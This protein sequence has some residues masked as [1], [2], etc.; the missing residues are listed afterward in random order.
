MRNQFKGFYTPK[1]NELANL[2]EN[3]NTIFVFDTNVL[4]NFYS[5]EENTRKDFFGVLDRICSRVWLPHQVVLEYQMRRLEIIDQERATFDRIL[6]CFSDI[7]NKI[8]SK[9]IAELKI[10]KRLPILAEALEGLLEEIT[11]LT[12]KF[13]EDIFKKQ[14]NL[15]PDVRS[16]DA[17]R[18]GFDKIFDSRVGEPFSA[19]ELQ[20]IYTEGSL[21]Y[22]KKIP[23]GFKDSKKSGVNDYVYAGLEYKREYGDY[24]IWKQ[25][26]RMAMSEQVHNVVFVTD[27]MKD[28]WW[29]QI[30]TKIIGPLESLQTEFYSVTNTSNFKMYDTTLFLKD[31]TEFLNAKI[32]ESSFSEVSNII[33]LNR[34]ENNNSSVDDL[35][36]SIPSTTYNDEIRKKAMEALANL[37]NT[38]KEYQP[39][40]SWRKALSSSSIYDDLFHIKISPNQKDDKLDDSKGD[41]FIDESDTKY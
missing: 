32:E 18:E 12:E 22:N 28:D 35:N 13:K 27:D 41:D 9:L 15:K 21:R 3:P 1:A 23:P 31:A 24:V 26:L 14:R 11:S 4:L 16:H 34:E 25:I 38:N 6:N 37:F 39:E 10:K 29:Y 33:K 30:G 2:W 20:S 7:E 40:N 19:E 36:D 17:I 5:Y 8:N